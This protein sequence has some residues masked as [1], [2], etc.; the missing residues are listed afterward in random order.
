VTPLVPWFVRFALVA[1]PAAAAGAWLRPDTFLLLAVLS[2][3]AAG[4]Y[5]L[6][7]VTPLLRSSAGAYLQP[8][9][10][11]FGRGVSAA[12]LRSTGAG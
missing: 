3:A 5:A 8:M 4:L 10:A 2:S 11:R 1:A 7:V 9:V 6:A 12:A